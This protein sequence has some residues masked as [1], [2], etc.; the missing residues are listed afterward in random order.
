MY[1]LDTDILTA[2][3]D[4]PTDLA[5]RQWVRSQQARTLHVSVTTIGALQRD[6]IRMRTFHRDTA[7]HLAEWLE[8]LIMVH[9]HRILELDVSTARRWGQLSAELRSDSAHLLIAAT[10]LEHRLTVVTRNTEAFEPTGASILNPHDRA[11]F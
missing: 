8:T 6:V 7:E 10:A 2:L 5:V 4:R 9:S 1:L 3:R 11:G